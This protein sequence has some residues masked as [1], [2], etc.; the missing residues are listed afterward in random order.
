MLIIVESPAKAKTISKIVGSD[1]KVKASVGHIRKISDDKK[2]KDGKPLEINGIDIEND[3]SPMFEIDPKKKDVVAEL[4]KLAKGENEIL[5]A[6]DFDREGEAISW[7]LTEVLGIKDKSKV[8]RLEF[9]E[10]TKKAILEALANPKVLRMNLVNAQKARQVI[11]KLVGYKVSPLLWRAMGKN[12]L[13]AGRVQSPALKLIVDREKEILAFVPEEYWLVKGIFGQ[14]TPQ[15]LVKNSSETELKDNDSTLLEDGL[16]LELKSIKGNKIDRITELAKVKEFETSIINDRNYIFKNI[17]TKTTT[18]KPKAPFTTSTLQ[19]S[20]NS[21]LG[22]VPKS[23]MSYAQKLYEGV[24]ID[25]QPTAL[26]TYMRTDSVNLSEDAI[27][28]IREHIGANYPDA[29]PI[30][31]NLYTSKSKNAQEAH[32][33]I[34]PTNINITPT[35]VRS[36]LDPELY[37]LYN[38]IW[39]QTMAC[40]MKEEKR[41]ILTIELE[42]SKEALFSGSVSWTTFPGYKLVFPELITPKPDNI[43]FTKGA[44]TSL[45]Q[46]NQF[47]KFTTPPS[48]YSQA[49]LIK[50]LEELGIGRPSTYASI[51]A[52]I[53]DREYVEKGASM[54][55][56]PLG[57]KIAELLDSLLP[58][59]TSS[60]LTADMEDRLDQIANGKAEYIA[61]LNHF[62]LPLKAKVDGEMKDVINIRQ[63]FSTME[64]DE[65]CP[66][67]NSDM[68]LKI[69]RFGDYLQCKEVKEHRF[70]KNYKEYNLALAEATNLYNEQT[71]G[72]KCEVCGKD[73]IVRVSK[74]TLNPYIACPDYTVGNK[75][76]IT[77]VNFGDCPECKKNNR[78]GVLVKKRGFKGNSFIGCS[79]PK[80]ECGYIQPKNVVETIN[81]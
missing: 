48:R 26:I 3:Y 60:T 25:G 61:T 14:K 31:P 23:T 65:K 70:A 20:A 5:F 11:D 74:S 53:Q 73:L 16:Y 78:T 8:K 7:H 32:E 50:E 56:T 17:I 49:S 33:A 75:H 72:K 54:K 47:Q 28:A 40:Q 13:S 52:T 64:T 4:K 21:K 71:K 63:Q 34:R 51:I 39:C 42:N 79:L 22:F 76:S 62:W 24:S 10:I 66:T 57:M 67:C 27:K 37:K 36:K 59:L 35:S 44:S 45:N 12:T 19:Q 2:T 77:S 30:T 81:N 80:E 1:Y 6:T 9:H 18:Q 58:N 15:L 43:N 69:G 38:L 41:E 55:P 68:E 29:L 46:L